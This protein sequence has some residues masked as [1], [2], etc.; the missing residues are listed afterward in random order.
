MANREILIERK[1]ERVSGYRDKKEVEQ[2]F[3]LIDE[4]S[5][6]SNYF[7]FATH[8]SL[9]VDNSDFSNPFSVDYFHIKSLLKADRFLN[10]KTTYSNNIREFTFGLH[11]LSNYSFNKKE[12]HIF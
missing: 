1:I 11:G 9:I 4:P 2:Y 7:R 10:P 3:D 8:K 5:Y 12:M 6:L